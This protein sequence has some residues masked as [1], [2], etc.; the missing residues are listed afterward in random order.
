[1]L[2]EIFPRRVDAH[3]WEQNRVRAK[4][5]RS[6][7]LIASSRGSI[8]GRAGDKIIVQTTRTCK[9]SN[10]IIFNH[11]PDLIRST[12]IEINSFSKQALIFCNVARKI[13]SSLRDHCLFWYFDTQFRFQRPDRQKGRP[14]HQNNR[15][16]RG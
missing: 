12:W 10:H 6:R 5:I 13:P 9:R 16:G 11:A 3:C 15:P 2:V 8:M 14:Y 1:M 7:G 4:K